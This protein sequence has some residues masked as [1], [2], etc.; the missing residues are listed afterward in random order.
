VRHVIEIAVGTSYNTDLKQR[1]K[2]LKISQGE[3]AREAGWTASH[4]S[5]WFRS[6]TAPTMR[7]VQRIEAAI[8]SILKRREKEQGKT[9]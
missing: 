6:P 3:L 7:S 9:K 5:R 8:A 4:V 2:K 1:L